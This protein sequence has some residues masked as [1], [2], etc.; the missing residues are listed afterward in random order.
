MKNPMETVSV[1]SKQSSPKFI[2]PAGNPN[3]QT[4]V[5]SS[6]HFV[7]AKCIDSDFSLGQMIVAEQHKPLKDE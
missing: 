2:V 6:A 3:Q 4:S 1:A 7:V 5:R